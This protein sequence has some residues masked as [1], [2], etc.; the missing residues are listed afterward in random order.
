[1]RRGT[2]GA[3]AAPMSGDAPRG[4]RVLVVDDDALVARS[5]ALVLGVEHEVTVAADALEAV[6]RIERG[7][8]YDVIL[9]D[10]MMPE[11]SGM[12]LHGRVVSL[13]P[14]TAARIVFVTGCAVQP[15]ARAFLDRV[16]NACLEKPFDMDALR[17]FVGRRVAQSVQRSA[18]S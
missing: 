5:I 1:M 7:E 16:P 2:A 17:E 4:G 3:P 6:S 12:E 11:T 13:D 10:L 14:V 9:C 8:R 15:E 18:F